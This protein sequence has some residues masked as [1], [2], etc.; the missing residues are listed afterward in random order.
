MASGTCCWGRRR[1][2]YGRHWTAWRMAARS[3]PGPSVLPGFLYS[4]FDLSRASSLPQWLGVVHKTCDRHLPPVGA[5]LLAMGPVL[6]ASSPSLYPT[7]K[8]SSAN[9]RQK[10]RLKVINQELAT[11]R[12]NRQRIIPTSNSQHT[13]PDIRGRFQLRCLLQNKILQP[14]TVIYSHSHAVN[15][16]TPQ[17]CLGT[18]QSTIKLSI[19]R[20][21]RNEVCDS[22]GILVSG[23][24]STS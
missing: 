21:G 20:I 14:S 1:R 5:S 6:I 2:G 8:L 19:R 3:M 18:E 11:V 16:G 15:R 9:P 4:S 24:V 7:E 23:E 22:I 12:N 10:P 17:R 13:H